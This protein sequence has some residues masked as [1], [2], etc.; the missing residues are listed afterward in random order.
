MRDKDKTR[1]ELIAELAE[2]RQR[3]AELEATDADRKWVE[4]RPEHLNLVLRAIR[5]VNLL[6]TR[7]K[8]RDRLLQG[9]CDRLVETRGYYNAWIALL[10]EAGG[11]VTTAE[12]GLGEKFTPLVERLK[13][14]ELTACGRRAL[15]Q[16]G[17]VVTEDPLSTCA[18]CPLSAHYGGRGVLTV[19]LEHGGKV[20]GL[21]SASIPAHL[22][23][24]REEQILFEEVA[25]DIAFALHSI[26]LEEERVR[27]EEE[28]RESEAHL[29]GLFETMAE[30]VIFIAPDGQIVQANPAAERILGLKRSN[31]EARNYVAPEWEILRPD[32]TPMPPDEMA[33]PRAMREMRPVKD[34]VMGVKRPDGTISW[35]NVSAAPVMT[36]SGEFEG[37]VG[38]FADITERKQAE[39]LLQALNRAAL[40]M[41]Q[42]F[43]TEEIFAALAGEL[44]KTGLSCAV[45]LTDEGQS[46][47]F[48][49]YLTYET[50][51]IKAAEKLVGLKLEDF[52]I[53]I[54]RVDAYR[55][56][57]W[58]RKTVFVEDVEELVRQLLPGPLERFAGRIVNM[59]GIPRALDAP[60]IIE[61]EVIGV[62]AVQSHDLTE[63]DAP[64]I[65]AF[66]HQMAAAWQK[67]QLF[68]QV[69]ASRERLRDLAGHLQDGREKERAYVAREIH[70]EFG[71]ALTALKMDLSWL[72]KRLPADEPRLAKRAGA[73]SEL[74][75]STIQTV[76]R[77]ATELRPGLLD[78]L[79]LVAALEWQAEEFAE[80]SGIDCELHVG[81][82]E[83]VLHENL[84]T[85]LFRI[86]QETL[87][88]VA[89]HAEA[90]EVHVELEDRPHELVLIVRDNG[91]GITADQ[92][93]SA[94]SLGLIGIRERAH[95]WGGDVV[96]HGIPGQG[97]TVTV[98]IPRAGGR[99]K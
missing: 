55:E 50:T 93:S 3:I 81:E 11:L 32:G 82:E 64:A 72:S 2:M 1:E 40:A 61:D 67:V 65:T 52:S 58:E 90:T 79:G 48:P 92:V 94:K 99:R 38:T 97:T 5:S 96:F 71:Q 8:D 15:S 31:I 77:V 12:A 25:G 83:I 75:D 69:Q 47:L 37:V 46:R 17:V 57:V 6:I 7:E 66:A 85:A 19:R 95:F 45:F 10:D 14:G 18:D 80:R 98:R 51:A 13:R 34:V 20:Y 22:T 70:D 62:L 76:R 74:I 35:I 68:G 59:L 33:A 27:A 4:E 49:K 56:A 9:A 86:F 23:A 16:S 30:G 73:M 91:K 84:A 36:E 41:E 87:T 44:K 29:Q 63:A 89:R 43:T 26:E 42:A 54:E 21:L 78:D 39:R 28:L 53:P 88:N 60:L 24:D